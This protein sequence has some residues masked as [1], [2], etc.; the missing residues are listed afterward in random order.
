MVRD[1]AKDG[2]GRS[3]QSMR[4]AEQRSNRKPGI[5]GPRRREVR[6]SVGITGIRRIEEVLMDKTS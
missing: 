2:A 5:K 3:E 6:R 1:S 4:G